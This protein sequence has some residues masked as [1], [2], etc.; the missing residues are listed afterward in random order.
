MGQRRPDHGVHACGS[1][2][3][4]GLR[5]REKLWHGHHGNACDLAGEFGTQPVGA[6]VER[7]ARTTY[8]FSHEGFG[9]LLRAFGEIRRRYRCAGT[10]VNLHGACA[11]GIDQARH[12]GASTRVWGIP[13]RNSLA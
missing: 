6:I 2:Q 12:E 4:A 13:V 3:V 11:N 7:D 10:V 5:G 9:Q 8:V 1:D